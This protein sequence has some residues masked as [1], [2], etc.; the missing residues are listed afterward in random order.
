MAITQSKKVIVTKT[1]KKIFKIDEIDANKI[2]VS[3]EEPYGKKNSF[4]YLIGYNDELCFLK[5]FGEK[6][7]V[8]SVK[9]L[10]S[11]IKSINPI[12]KH[13]HITESCAGILKMFPSCFYR[14]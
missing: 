3:K 11:N 9:L 7:L 10:P 1:Y 12:Q 14:W 4:K 6:I 8:K 2:L 5:S 13:P